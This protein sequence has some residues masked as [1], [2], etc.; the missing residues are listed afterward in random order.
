MPS[1]R[2]RGISILNAGVFNSGLTA[3]AWPADDAR[4]EYGPAPAALLERARHM[5]R[6][7]ADHGST[8]P[9]AALKYAARAPAVASVVIGAD[10]PA[11]LAQ[12]INALEEPRELAPLWAE[13][14]L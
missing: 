14:G 2:E 9:Q 13:L 8:L 5:A 3:A 7:A 11:Q 12:S 6:L 10:G 4:Y 1:R